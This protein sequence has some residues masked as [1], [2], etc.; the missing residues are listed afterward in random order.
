MSGMTLTNRGWIDLRPIE[1]FPFGDYQQKKTE[2]RFIAK[3]H[4]MPCN[5]SSSSV[6]KPMSFRQ[7]QPSS[8]AA[9]ASLFQPIA[10]KL[11]S[12][13]LEYSFFCAHSAAF[14]E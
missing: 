14:R 6:L 12:Q 10:V 4:A 1:R 8:K 7:W 5:P 9:C 3:H 2:Q 13:I 11:F